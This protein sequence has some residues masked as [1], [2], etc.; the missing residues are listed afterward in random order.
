MCLH[1]MLV[2]HATGGQ[3][4]AANAA[5][6]WRQLGELSYHKS[7]TALKPQKA[8]LHFVAHFMGFHCLVIANAIVATHCCCKL[9]LLLPGHIYLLAGHGCGDAF[10]RTYRQKE[11]DR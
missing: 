10:Y 6:A 1:Q 4:A 8:F 3:V 9:L 7:F 2:G 5:P 11:S